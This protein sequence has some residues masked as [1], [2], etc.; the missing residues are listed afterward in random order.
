VSG[1]VAGAA[2][3]VDFGTS[4]GALRPIWRSIGYDE[5]N[6][7]YTPRGRALYD[8]LGRIFGGPLSVRNHNAFTSGNG[9]SSPAWGS[10]NLYHERS[11]GSMHLDWT[12]SDQIYD[13]L[14]EHGCLPIIELGFMPRDLSSHPTDLAGYRPGRGL[15][16]EPYESR[17]WTYPPKSYTRWRELCQG[18]V[19]HLVDRYGAPRV[20][21][22]RFEVWNEPDIPHYWQGSCEEYCQLYEASVAGVAAALPDAQI[23]GPAT[24]DHGPE[25]LAQVLDRVSRLDFASFHSKGAYYAVRRNYNPVIPP[26]QESPSLARMLGDIERSVAII[27][28]R[29]P[30]VPIIVDECDPAVGT[31]YGVFDNPNFEV[32]NSTYYP[33]MLCALAA[34]LLDMGQIDQFTSWAFY[35]EGKRWFEGN[36]V[37]VT[38]ENV[39]LPVL[40]GFR[41]LERLGD[42]RA[43]ASVDTK[44]PGVGVL[45]G[46]QAAILYN[47]VDA[48]WDERVTPVTLQFTGAGRAVRFWRLGDSYTRWRDLGSPQKPSPSQVEA[49]R[50]AS[51]LA[52]VETVSTEGGRLEHRLAL[53]AHQALL[54]EP[55]P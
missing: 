17:A 16:G 51:G 5:I 22:W 18:F 48:W 15:G 25:F 11:D 43:D 33:T 39:E 38:N 27:R 54:C 44:D 8:G 47:H 19:A 35:F 6:W 12:W 36:R 7:T 45:A 50:A 29:F 3:R 40:D 42:R 26:P 9:L 46:N 49:L 41:M 52:A 21:Q 55:V 31:I 53:P 14:V 34:N 13:V 28:E 32:C 23:G 30:D 2:V 1:P 24:T 10:T 20:R 37:L 4:T